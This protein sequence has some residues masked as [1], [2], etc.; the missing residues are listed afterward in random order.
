VQ[1]ALLPRKLEN[2]K[3]LAGAN[4]TPINIAGAQELDIEIFFLIIWG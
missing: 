1:L 3:C 4:Q 2:K